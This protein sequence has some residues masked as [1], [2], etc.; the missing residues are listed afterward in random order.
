MISRP[1]AR[2][3]V[4]VCVLWIG[5]CLGA[6]TRS[7]TAASAPSQAHCVT[8]EY[9]Q[10]DFWIGDWDAFD[11][12]SPKPS[13]HIRVERALEGCA[14]REIY[15]GV[16]GERGESLSAYDASRG[17]WHQSWFT[18]RGYVLL[19]EGHLTNQGMI[20]EG[21]EQTAKGQTLVRG[22]W[23]AVDGGVREIAVMSSDRGHTWKPWFDL[24]FR[25]HRH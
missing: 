7:H 2:L 9:H 5:V 23:R 25:P 3:M 4:S 15:E 20:L 22:V 18:N 13:A 1:L 14:L 12:D 21:T 16:D 17:V 19:I 8:P 6:V 11:I 10:L 24:M